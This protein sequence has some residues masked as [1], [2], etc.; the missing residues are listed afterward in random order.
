[1][2]L[3]KLPW[4]ITHKCSKTQHS[5]PLQSLSRGGWLI[6]SNFWHRMPPLQLL[7]LMPKTAGPKH[8]V[9]SFLQR[10]H[11]WSALHLLCTGR[12][13]QRGRKPLLQT[14][15]C[16]LKAPEEVSGPF[17]PELTHS[18]HKTILFR[19]RRWLLTGGI[20]IACGHQTQDQAEIHHWDHGGGYK[21]ALFVPALRGTAKGEPLMSPLPPLCFSPLGE[22]FCDAEAH[23]L[24]KSKMPACLHLKMRQKSHYF[25]K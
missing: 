11:L 1:M 15:T 21:P 7:L 25:T 3:D 18:T 2:K 20:C 16:S 5:A 9:K 19:A 22:D 23:C 6:Q 12:R 8:W 10:L 4:Y 14:F 24:L 17:L 13:G